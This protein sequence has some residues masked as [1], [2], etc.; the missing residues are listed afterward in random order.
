MSAWLTTVMS[1]PQ[2]ASTPTSLAAGVTLVGALSP[3][4]RV[5]SSVGTTKS[6]T[7][8]VNTPLQETVLSAV[9]AQFPA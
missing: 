7:V 5:R 6:G 3:R 8:S 4:I 1:P 9:V 2:S